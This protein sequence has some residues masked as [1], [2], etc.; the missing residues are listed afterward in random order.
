MFQFI[1]AQLEYHKRSVMVLDNILPTLK[2][3]LGKLRDFLLI[4]F[5]NC[6]VSS[7]PDRLFQSPAH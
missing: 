3:L 4:F 1:E 5:D 2:S 6:L 7:N